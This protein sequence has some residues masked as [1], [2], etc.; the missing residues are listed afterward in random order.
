MPSFADYQPPHYTGLTLE[1]MQG[2]RTNVK[3]PG[4]SLNAAGNIGL[5]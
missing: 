1:R 3:G 5:T 2:M 4:Q